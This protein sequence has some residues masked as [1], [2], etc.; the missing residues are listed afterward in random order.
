MVDTSLQSERRGG[1][2]GGK[3]GGRVEGGPGELLLPRRAPSLSGGRAR[4]REWFY[5]TFVVFYLF[6]LLFLLFS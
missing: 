6:Q 5:F 2:E 3:G 1:G 4:G